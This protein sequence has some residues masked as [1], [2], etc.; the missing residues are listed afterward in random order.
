MVAGGLEHEVRRLVEGGFGFELPAM[1][2]L[3]YGEWRGVLA[4]EIDQEQAVVLIRRNTRR[5]IRAQYAWFRLED[6][7]IA[8]FDLDQDGYETLLDFVAQRAQAPRP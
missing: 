6:P 3:G 4:G 5:F 7:E 2:A 8:W 1:S